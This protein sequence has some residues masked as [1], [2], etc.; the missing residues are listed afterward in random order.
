MQQTLAS[1]LIS[2]R[3]RQLHSDADHERLAKLATERTRATW[4]RQTG[5]VARRLSAALDDFA[6]QLDPAPCRP[7]FSRD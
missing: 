6:G 1:F 4:R 3:I 5:H 7:S 2:E